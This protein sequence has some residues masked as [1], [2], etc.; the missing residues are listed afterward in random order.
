MLSLR[1]A[2]TLMIL[3][4]ACA[5]LA[6]RPSVPY[7]FDVPA[8]WTTTSLGDDGTMVSSGDAYVRIVKI[9]GGGKD[10]LLV[11]RVVDQI[12]EQ[13]KQFKQDERGQAKLA[14]STG[15][16]LF[17]SGVNPKG[18]EATMRIVAA[19][20][21]DDAYML[22]MSAPTKDFLN[23][24]EAFK[25]IEHTFALSPGDARP[26]VGGDLPARPAP[27]AGD[28]PARSAPAGLKAVDEAGGGHILF[29]PLTGA[30][31]GPDAFRSGLGKIHGYFDASP[32]LL[33]VV[34][35]KDHNITISVFSASLRGS[36]VAGFATSNYDPAGNS[37]FAVV[38]D[39]P[40]HLRTSLTPMMRHVHDM[41]ESA[42][43][44][45]QPAGHGPA[46]DFAKFEAAAGH[47]ALTRTQYP[48][49]IGSIGIASN[50][51]P[52]LHSDGS[53]VA[54]GE[55]G[56]YMNL[57][58][59]DNMLDPRGSN[60]KLQQQLA[61]NIGKTSL[62]PIPGQVFIEYDA[63][64]VSAWKKFITEISRQHGTP[65]LNPQVQHEGPMKGVT[66]PWTGRLVSGTMT[67]N[68]EPFAFTG[69]LMTS[70][71]PSAQGAWSLG[72][73]ILAAPIKNAAK[74]FPA[75]LAMQKSVRLD[76]GALRDQT[77]RN[78]ARMNEESTRWLAENGAAGDAARNSR[79]AS[80]M[81][82]ARA[83]RDAMDRSTAGFINHIL[84][85]SVIQHNPTGA[86]GTMD[87]GLASALERS[88]PQNF[89][90][91]PISQY[92]KGVDY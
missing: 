9:P 37:H 48:G 42:I 15:I 39:S 16:Y 82:N 18:I 34:T 91:V 50:Y 92:V 21:G 41:A 17:F 69:S 65:D 8:G 63:D 36:P 79:V 70:P 40:D 78:I 24:K 57:M 72:V 19:P 33:S 88:D 73:T 27:A 45:S 1:F 83:S 55:D 26:A 32:K 59:A 49:G 86:H 77:N 80:S 68:G 74:D 7:T 28:L 60:Y 10:E 4:V 25:Q 12:G 46:I 62:P 56:S 31:S 53:C 75:L 47:V 51:K 5:A 13:W 84:D 71:P 64:P 38:F 67:I 14:G 85:R 11:R 90:P 2:F 30:S 54:I 23:I 52:N 81:A 66:A 44:H 87:S 76:M 22:I 35:S 20:F 3:T 89:S 58:G 6:Q 61:H 29:S 43:E